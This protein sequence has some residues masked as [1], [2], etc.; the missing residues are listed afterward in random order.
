MAISLA[1]LKKSTAKPPRIIIHG[2]PGCGKTTFGCAAPNPV[3]IRTEDGLGVLTVD[4]FPIAESYQDV[5]DAIGALYTEEHS[6]KTLVIDSLDWLEPLIWQKVCSD[7]KIKNIEQQSYG[8]GYVEALYHW[9]T[10]F[11]GITALRDHKNM[12]VIMTAHSEIKKVEDPTMPSYDRHDLKLHKRASALA[13]EFSDVILYATLMT[14]TVSEDQGFGNKRVRAVTT[15]E[16]LMHTV[17]QPAFLA[18]SR[19]P[20]PSPL[21]LEWD[22]LSEALGSNLKAAA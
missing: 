15:G 18:K 9:R 13:D 1:S 16:R 4:T 20:I 6:F 5:I 7:N 2:P 17:G 14:K 11:D 19:F 10:F 12:I 8:K 21:P 3:V 22:A